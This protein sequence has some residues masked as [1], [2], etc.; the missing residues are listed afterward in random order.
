[1]RALLV[2]N[3]NATSTSQAV[4]DVIAGALAAATKLD[5]E[6]TKRRA[7]AGYLAAGAVHEGY[8]VVFALGGD[9]TLNE[10][11]QGVAGTP[12]RLGLIPGGSA[13]VF[14]RILGIPTDPLEATAA[15]LRHLERREDRHIPLGRANG[16]WFTFCAGYG[17]D[18]EVVRQVEE[19]GRM[20]RVAKQA[21]FLWCGLRAQ[22]AG[23]TRVPQI[24]VRVDGADPVEDLR[25][26]VVCNADPYTFLGPLPSRMCP[27]A[28]LDGG[29]DA[30]GLTRGRLTDV[31]RL[32]RTAL[33]TEKVPEL[34]FTRS[35]NDLVGL[36]AE[37]ATPLAVHTDGEVCPPTTRLRLEL[38]PHALRVL[39]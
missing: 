27:G 22:L 25:S 20:K 33:F 10:V 34:A 16:R 36:T 2:H 18:A 35:W 12:I 28:E 7:H 38:V 23:A 3:P 9:G 26:L 6:G 32:M 21:T 13:N 4:V 8:D 31:A 14:A 1:M 19:T 39:A 30:T 17:Y 15:A 29:L 24:V 5:V 37:N 11:V